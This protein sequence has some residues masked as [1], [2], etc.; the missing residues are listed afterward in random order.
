M[1]TKNNTKTDVGDILIVDD[2]IPNL[3]LLTQLLSGAGYQVRPANDP[4]LAL[5]SAHA[6]PPS[7]ILLDVRMPEMDGFEV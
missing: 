4:Q 7:L 5:E 6:Q 3:E 1:P 2:D